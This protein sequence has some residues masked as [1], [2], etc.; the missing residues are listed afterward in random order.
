MGLNMCPNKKRRQQIRYRIPLISLA[1]ELSLSLSALRA[2]DYFERCSFFKKLLANDV[3]CDI[4][5]A[6]TE[7]YHCIIQ[8]RLAASFKQVNA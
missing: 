8:F 2:V 6:F 5:V 7:N 3:C 1:A 4:N